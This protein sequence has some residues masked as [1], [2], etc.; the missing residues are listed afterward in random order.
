V[1][2]PLK[3]LVVPKCGG[4]GTECGRKVVYVGC[5]HIAEDG[6]EVGMQ[7]RKEQRYLREYR[8][9]GWRLRA[10]ECLG[11]ELVP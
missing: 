4:Q 9:S 11:S 5:R 10:D 2:G 3:G 1:F 6:A 7:W 8:M